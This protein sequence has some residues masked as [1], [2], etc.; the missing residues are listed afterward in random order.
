M[1]RRALGFAVRAAVFGALCFYL[2]KKTSAMLGAVSWSGVSWRLFLGTAALSLSINIVLAGLKYNRL[3]R[4][5][6]IPVSCGEALRLEAATA[7]ASLVFPAKSENLLRAAYLSR[8]RGCRYSRALSAS[9]YHLYTNLVALLLATSVSFAFHRASLWYCGAIGGCLV[10]AAD[11]ALVALVRGATSEAGVPR[12]VSAAVHGAFLLV[13]I[14]Y[15]SSNT[16][17]FCLL[18]RS[19]HLVVP[20][21]TLCFYSYLI[22][23]ATYLPVSLAGLGLREASAVTLL[24]GAAPEAVV[25]GCALAVTMLEKFLPMV[26]GLPF[27]FTLTPVAARESRGRER[28][29]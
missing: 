26:I 17:F 28:D 4:F 23:L 20:F 7:S 13:S 22:G 14:V 9:A 5:W 3:Y 29:A 8:T 10:L 12:N 1:M 27:L 25:L 16:L 6:A 15:V 2:W 21:G 18:A 11:A 19:F 24:A